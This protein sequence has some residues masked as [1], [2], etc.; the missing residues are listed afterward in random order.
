[1]HN[2][3][4]LATI[5]LSALFGVRIRYCIYDSPCPCRLRVDSV[6]TSGVYHCVWKQSNGRGTQRGISSQVVR[7]G[8]SRERQGMLQAAMDLR[9]K[10]IHGGRAVINVRYSY[11]SKLSGDAVCENLLALEQ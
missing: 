3:S 11:D 4:P 5:V 2:S 10:I 9:T 6:L 8:L 1:M 7:L